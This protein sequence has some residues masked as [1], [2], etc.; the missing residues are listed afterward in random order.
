MCLWSGVTMGS[1]IYY[2]DL[3]TGALSKSVKFDPTTLSCYLA[4]YTIYLKQTKATILLKPCFKVL[5]L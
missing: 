1:I 3:Q 4:K 5:A 2:M